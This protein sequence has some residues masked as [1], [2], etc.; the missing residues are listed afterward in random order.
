MPRLAELRD[1]LERLLDDWAVPASMTTRMRVV[2]APIALALTHLLHLGEG[3]RD[4][5]GALDHL[6]GWLRTPYSGADP[7][8]VDLFEVHARR[9]QLTRGELLGRWEGEAIAPARRMVRAAQAGPRAQIAAMLEVGWD[10]L[11][12]CD[13]DGHA[14]RRADLHDRAAL[15]ALAGLTRAFGDDDEAEEEPAPP[16]RARGPLPP[17]EL[18]AIVADLTAMVRTET[19]GGLEL[20]D[21]AS[22]R[23]RR[24]DVVVV[25]GLDGDGFPSRPAAD[26][27]LGGLRSALGDDLPPRAP[28][29][30]ESRMRFVHAIDAA[31]RGSGW[32]DGWWTTPDARWRPRPTGSRPAG[33]RGARS[34]T[35]TGAPAPGARCRSPAPPPAPSGRP[36]APWRSRT[37]ATPACWTTP[38]RGAPG[39]SGS[40][41]TP[42]T[43]ATASG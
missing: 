17:G 9:A 40:R 7:R 25:A 34:M 19:P 21:F 2:E 26:P 16:G 15:A 1:E 10:A 36:C 6:L 11:R 18:G 14:P 8:D 12:R 28:G 20:H 27:F 42:S 22:I 29:T 38:P 32:C 31:R 4:D 35:S 24:Y 33:W 43:T 23:G 41:R 3:E 30:S 5:P 37:G 39:P 13:A